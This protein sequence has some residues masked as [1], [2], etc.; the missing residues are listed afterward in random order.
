[1]RSTNFLVAT[2]DRNFNMWKFSDEKLQFIEHIAEHVK[3]LEEI[4]E[5]HHFYIDE[6]AFK[7]LGEKNFPLR[8][9]RVFSRQP[10]KV[11]KSKNWRVHDM[12]ELSSVI[13][14]KERFSPDVQIFFIG[15][16]DFLETCT[17][18]ARKLLLTVVDKNYTLADG[19]VDKFPLES[20]KQKFHK[21]RSI[22]P[23]MLDQIKKYKEIIN[24]TSSKIETIV[25]DN[26]MLMKREVEAPTIQEDDQIL[27]TPDYMFYEYSR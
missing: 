1:M 25:T 17:S 23:E 10:G 12:N 14:A 20:I 15:T 22:K 19:V 27:N 7:A 13:S 4:S 3:R 9:T 11:E 26:G 16:A 2:I 5:N 8:F 6:T 24:R 21:R 18:Y